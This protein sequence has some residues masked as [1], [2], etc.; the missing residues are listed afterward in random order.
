MDLKKQNGENY[1]HLSYF[2]KTQK[3]KANLTYCLGIYMHCGIHIYV[4]CMCACQSLS[5]VPFFVIPSNVTHQAPL[6]RILEW[7]SI[8]FSRGSS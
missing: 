8:P 6:S 3:Q 2:L 1:V 5:Q 7:V 4:V